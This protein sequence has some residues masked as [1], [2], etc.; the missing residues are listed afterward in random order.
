[1]VVFYGCFCTLVTTASGVGGRAGVAGG[2]GTAGSCAA[3]G[4]GCSVITGSGDR[5]TTLG[6]LLAPAATLVLP[7]LLTRPFVGRFWG[8]HR[9]TERH[10]RGDSASTRK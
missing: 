3:A 6:V 2:E 4:R 8:A 1:M 7:T 10:G 9:K 5:R